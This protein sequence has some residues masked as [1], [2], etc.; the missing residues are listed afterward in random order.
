M[1][2]TDFQ[3]HVVTRHLKLFIKLTQ[4]WKHLFSRW[5]LVKLLALLRV[6]KTWNHVVFQN[7]IDGRKACNFF[8]KTL[9]HKCFFVNYAKILRTPTFIEHIW[10]LL[11]KIMKSIKILA[12]TSNCLGI[13]ARWRVR[14]RKPKFS[15][16][17]LTLTFYLSMISMKLFL[18]FHKKWLSNLYLQ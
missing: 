11:L 16:K 10:W 18:L 17:K 1:E 3:N 14:R 5:L 7:L 8:K 2:S 9:W 4:F 12:K 6:I 13:A 15:S